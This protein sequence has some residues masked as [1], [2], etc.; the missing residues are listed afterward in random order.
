[1]KRHIPFLVWGLAFVLFTLPANAQTY[2]SDDTA[3]TLLSGFGGA[4]IIEGGDILVGSAGQTSGPGEVYVYRKMDGEWKEATRIK[5][6]DGGDDNRFGRALA[7]DGSTLLVGATIQNN[8]EGAVYVFEKD[9]QGNWIEKGTLVP[10]SIAEGDNYGRAVSISGD[11]A[12]AAT[13]GHNEGRGAVYAFQKDADGNWV[14]TQMLAPDSLQSGDFFGLSIS[15]FGDR[16]IVGAPAYQR[17][18]AS[19]AAYVFKFDAGSGTW[20]EE[21]MLVNEDLDSRGAFGASVLFNGPYAIVGAP[22]AEEFAGKVFIYAYDEQAEEWARVDQLAAFDGSSRGQYGNTLAMVDNALW[23]G[24]PGAGG[25]G[26]VYIHDFDFNAMNWSGVSKIWAAEGSGGSQFGSMFYVDGDLAVV[27]AA[28]MDNG[29][30][31]AYIYA[32]NEMGKWEQQTMVYNEIEG[33]DPVLGAK[34]D[35]QDGD[36]SIFSCESVDLISFLPLNKLAGGRGSHV[37]DVWGWTDPETGTEYTL[38]GRTDGTSFVDIS[39][40]YNPVVVGNLW[41]TDGAQPASWRDIKV[42]KDHAFIVADGA[43]PHGMQIF[44]LNQ[45]RDVKPADMPVEFKETAHYDQVASVHNIV[46][47][48]DTGFGYAVGSNAGGVTCGGGLHIINIQEPLNPTFAGCFADESTGRAS[49]GYTHDAQ[50]VTYAGPDVEHQGKEICFNANETALSIGDVTDKE[51]TVPL[52]R[53]AYPNVGYSHQGWL[54]EDHKYFFMNDELDEMQGKVSQTRTLI[55]DVQ[56]LDDPQLVKEFLLDSPAIDHNL[57]IKGNLMYQAN[58]TSGLRILDITDVEN[59]VEVGYFDTT[60]F[61]ENAAEFD[62]AWSNYPYF[63]S[64]I[65]P[66]SSIGQGLFL[67]KKSNVDI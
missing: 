43:G 38:L 28:G 63:K 29:E 51:N 36:A 5:A 8:N 34:V 39:D 27:G 41:L 19:G 37:N 45:L 30:G 12:F 24:A 26:A 67:V 53:A 57:Y 16:V 50:C 60:P 10:A 22:G 66:I 44:D 64:G 61:G 21:A 15:S 49:T 17:Q 58:Y 1:M 13:V 4:A 55:W 7:I 46:I 35:C 3:N 25:T 23:V 48:E 14:E 59:P 6:S 11:F 31:G 20:R 65:I 42:Y 40:P 2:R 47:N 33:M 9:G 62:G 56:D 54:T 32:R 18:N 52:S